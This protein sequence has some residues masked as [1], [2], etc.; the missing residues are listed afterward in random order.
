MFPGCVAANDD[1][2]NPSSIQ[3]ALGIVYCWKRTT[4]TPIARLF[5]PKALRL[6]LVDSNGNKINKYKQ[7]IY[8]NSNRV[9]SKKETKITSYNLSKL[10]STYF[11]P[12]VFFLKK[13]EFF[14]MI[15]AIRLVQS[16]TIMNPTAAK[17][18][19]RIIFLLFLRRGV[20]RGRNRFPFFLFRNV[21]TV[22]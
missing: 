10:H 18:R 11:S 21:Q 14:S 3:I 16:F 19:I 5:K 20:E 2:F 22:G 4:T 6:L 1:H 13:G 15:P 12:L 17:K 9:A 8:R 7:K